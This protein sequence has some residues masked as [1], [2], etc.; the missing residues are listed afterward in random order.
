MRD[1]MQK[2]VILAE[3]DATLSAFAESVRRH[4]LHAAYPVSQDRHVVGVI[5]MRS[6]GAVPVEKW[7]YTRVN[8]LADRE[9]VRI[10]ADCDVAEALRLLTQERRQHMLLVQSSQGELEGILTKSDLLSALTIR[11]ANGHRRR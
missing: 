10:S 11:N 3:G 2:Q 5:A 1:V 7:E 8:E 6:L 4:E 9:A